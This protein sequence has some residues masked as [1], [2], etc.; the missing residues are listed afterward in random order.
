MTTANATRS[1]ALQTGR[2]LQIP[3]RVCRPRVMAMSPTRGLPR[4]LRAASLGSVGFVLAL[5]AHLAAGGEAPG[6][7]ALLLLAGLIGLVALLLTRVQL[8]SVEIGVSLTALQVILHEIFMRL[9]T[10][11]MAD[12]G[13]GQ[14][15]TYTATAMIGAHVIA[16]A[17]MVALLAYGEKV[18]WFL[19]GCM[20]PPRW[21]RAGLPELPAVRD[22]PSGTPRMLPAQFADGGV[23]RRGP[24]SRGLF[25]CL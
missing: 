8:S 25:A 9:G 18:L 14:R 13:M 15:S 1:R 3:C 16:T 11:G 20:R 24:P 4:A 10:T 12:A 2:H 6:R 17:V 22:I 7:V 21:L 5:V 23:G 19:A